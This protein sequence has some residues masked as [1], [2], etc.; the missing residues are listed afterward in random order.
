[1]SGDDY[2]ITLTPG[3]A[4]GADIYFA[5][6]PAVC[7]HNGAVLSNGGDYSYTLTEYGSEWN[8][9]YQTPTPFA[10]PEPGASEVL[11]LTVTAQDNVTTKEYTITVEN[12]VPSS[13]NNIAALS[14]QPKDAGT[15][16]DLTASDT[17]F[18]HTFDSEETTFD[19]KI[20]TEDSV[21]S[22][23]CAINGGAPSNLTANESKNQFTK[24][25]IP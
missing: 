6:D 10:A 7:Y 23:T 11:T 20:D 14:I 4:G 19:L 13:N 8:N 1:M 9:S 25:A 2:K 15:Y 21:K 3:T 18:S 16:T 17:T 12:P 22:V 24:T 5:V